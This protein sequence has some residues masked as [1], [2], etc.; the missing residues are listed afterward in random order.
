MKYEDAIN[1]LDFHYGLIHGDRNNNSIDQESLHYAL[2]TLQFKISNLDLSIYFIDI[3]NCLEV[4]NIQLNGSNPLELP[5]YDKTKM[6]D[7]RLVS[8][9]QGILHNIHHTEIELKYK[10]ADA[11]IIATLIKFR[12]VI[13]ECWIVILE[14]GDFEN[15][16]KDEV[17]PLMIYLNTMLDKQ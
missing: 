12:Y 17:E 16:N 6:L 4:I 11:K 3:I 5:Y 14:G 7:R 9:I 8:I 13:S 15:I 1:R 10:K 2:H